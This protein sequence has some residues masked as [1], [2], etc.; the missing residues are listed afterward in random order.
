[1]VCGRGARKVLRRDSAPDV[2]LELNISSTHILELLWLEI[3]FTR[4]GSSTVC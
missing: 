4:E 1:M 3:R 2:D